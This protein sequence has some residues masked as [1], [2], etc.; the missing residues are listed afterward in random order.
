MA[1]AKVKPKITVGVAD[2]YLA[3]GD[4]LKSRDIALESVHVAFHGR[5][6][7]VSLL[8]SGLWQACHDHDPADA[9][10]EVTVI[11]ADTF[12]EAVEACADAADDW[13]THGT[14]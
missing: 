1:K 2:L 7:A 11:V 9:E 13:E 12:V 8:P 14:T 5:S 10:A 6:I 3:L 4:R